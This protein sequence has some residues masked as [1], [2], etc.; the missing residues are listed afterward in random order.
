[1]YT[2]KRDGDRMLGPINRQLYASF[3]PKEHAFVVA[4]READKRGFTDCSGKLIQV[5]TDG[6]PDLTFYFQRHFPNAKH[7]IDVIHVVEK[8]WEAGESV[9]KEGTPEHRR[10]VHKQRNRLYDGKVHLILAELRGHLSSTPKTGPGN[11]GKRE[12][13]EKT[14]KYL[15]KRIDKMDYDK[16]VES[17]LEIAT[18]QVEGAIKNVIGKRCDHGGMRWIRERA[19]A[20][21][22][23]RCIEL[24]GDW[25]AFSNHVHDVTQDY[26]RQGGLRI[27]LQASEPR[28]VPVHPD[29]KWFQRRRAAKRAA[30]QRGLVL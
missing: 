15:D 8:L 23:L 1:M 6:D 3:A 27:R 18:G 19:E 28:P 11:K 10:W 5:V 30:A 4:R 22:Q 26:A 24:N 2:L 13:L 29:A 17:D 12:R 21:V 25:D 20:V 7:T 16:L 9:F 14:I